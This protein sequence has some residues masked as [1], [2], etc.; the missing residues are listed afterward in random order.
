MKVFAAALVMSVVCTVAGCSSGDDTS[1]AGPSSTA[2][3]GT[4]SVTV[5]DAYT[6]L[7]LIPIG[8]PTFPFLGTDGKYH[9][10]YDLQLTN[11]TPVPATLDKLD[12]VDGTDPST[13]IASFSGA[14]LVE[15]NC[16]YGDCNRLRMLT[17]PP[18]T[19]T[20]IP[21]QE[22]R[23][24]FVDYTFD[25]LDHAPKTVLHHLY[26]SAAAAP[27]AKEPSP[28]DYLVTALDIDAGTPRVISPPLKG[29]NWIALN[30]CCLPGFPHRTSPLPVDGK[31]NNSQR[32]AIDWKRTN[33]QGEF[34]TGDRTKNE[35]Y[36]DY[37]SDVYAV[38]DGTVVA[39]LDNV[40]AN[41][42]GTLPAEVP[43]LAAK[44][45][46]ENVDGNHVV[47]DLG[48]GVYAMYAHFIEGSLV[49][50]PGDQVKKGDKIAQLGNTG[51]ANASHLH[52]QLMNGPSLLYAD[53]LPYVFDSFEYEGQVAPQQILDAD[54]YLSGQFLQG[55]LP[56]GEPRTDQLP[57][58]LAI[59]DFP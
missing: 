45:T 20:A 18:A 19:S 51:N 9:V 31:I 26:G 14:A 46:V 44:L 59:V 6:G 28:V 16:P 35:S 15:P 1:E 48:G 36:V 39:T 30:G 33:D 34:Y 13:V 25:S 41:A 17:A 32:F 7:T 21:P 52:F 4:G 8:D 42:P 3:G 57:T 49:V 11:A 5:P 12:V 55:K 47:L 10:A 2:A 24:L 50:K 22:T 23:I 38:A 29:D 27:A 56:T 53:S 40:P 37:G 54:D 43:E 58:N